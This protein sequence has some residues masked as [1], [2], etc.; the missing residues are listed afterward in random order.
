MSMTR[1]QAK[2]LYEEAKD[3]ARRRNE[4]KQHSFPAFERKLGQRF[5]CSSCGC[6]ADLLYVTTY[7]AGFK[8]AGGDPNSIVPGYESKELQS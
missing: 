3:N 4:C 5:I 2:Q 6:S 7:A 8:A 1:E